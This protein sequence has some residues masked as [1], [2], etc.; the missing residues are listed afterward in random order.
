M[1]L[2]VFV[3]CLAVFVAIGLSSVRKAKGTH[4]DYYLAGRGVQPWLVGLSAVATN[5]SGYMFIGV[6]GFTYT[7]GLAAIWLMIGW[8]AGD[9]LAS[10][11]VHRRLRDATGASGEV[12]FPAVVAR[13]AGFE[14]GTFWAPM[15]PRRSLRA[16]RRC[17]ACWAGRRRLAR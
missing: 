16:E 7:T 3:I 5:N 4:D 2:A 8:I 6:I 15:P 11:F 17:R 13:W 1:T 9:F 10:L 14:L 12:S